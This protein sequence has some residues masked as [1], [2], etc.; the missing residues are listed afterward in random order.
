MKFKVFDRTQLLSD[1]VLANTL[2]LDFGALTA[3]AEALLP[4][5]AAAGQRWAEGYLGC[6]L[7]EQAISVWLQEWPTDG[8]FKLPVGGITAVLAVGYVDADGSPVV[9]DTANF[10]FVNAPYF[11]SELY[12]GDTDFQP[13]DF[14]KIWDLGKNNIYLTYEAGFDTWDELDPRIQQAITLK[15]CHFYMNKTNTVLTSSQYPDLL[16]ANELLD[17][18]LRE[19]KE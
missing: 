2:G 11:A 7:G 3:Q 9:M 1:E 17:Q 8:V 12:L 18:I 5:A 19:I 13:A 14:P 6:A 4:V 10:N 15:A 16:T